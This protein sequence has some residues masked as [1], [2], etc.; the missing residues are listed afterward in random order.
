LF[1]TAVPNT[2]LRVYTAV[3]LLLQYLIQAE[4]AQ[5]LLNTVPTIK[6]TGINKND[7]LINNALPTVQVP[8]DMLAPDTQGTSCIPYL[9]P[10][11]CAGVCIGPQGLSFWD[12]TDNK[13]IHKLRMFK[14]LCASTQ[15]TYRNAT[16]S[17]F[18]QDTRPLLM[19]NLP[20]P[21]I[22]QQIR[23]TLASLALRSLGLATTIA[24][25]NHLDAVT[26]FLLCPME[27]GGAQICDPIIRTCQDI[28]TALLGGLMHPN[29]VIRHSTQVTIEHSAKNDYGC[30]QNTEM[31]H[32][33][34]ESKYSD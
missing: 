28:G 8:G 23:N 30:S 15:Q 22:F 34:A 13:I 4:H 1:I 3:S 32:Q 21:N 20:N 14:G 6:V 29:K 17:I 5:R 9:G 26:D 16:M 10:I 19:S 24:E 7:Q 27:I 11:T 25:D 12:S 18:Y 31:R 33:D 2:K